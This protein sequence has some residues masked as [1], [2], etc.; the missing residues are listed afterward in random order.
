M[1]YR[2]PRNINYDASAVLESR[3]FAAGIDLPPG[4]QGYVTDS[5]NGRSRSTVKTIT[6]PLWAFN[7]NP[8]DERIHKN[9][10]SYAIYYYAHEAAHA[11]VSHNKV[12]DDS[13]HGRKFYEE[14]KRLCP[15]SLWHYELSYKPRDAKRAGI[16]KSPGINEAMARADGNPKATPVAPVA[17]AAG[18]TNDDDVYEAYVRRT[19]KLQTALKRRNV[20]DHERKSFIRGWA[21]L[22]K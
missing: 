6:V 20:P 12:K 22:D 11:W 8:R 1:A 16:D 5:N 15:P 9:D 18:P 13:P 19:P 14:F 21:K 7:M 2:K 3:A 4:W 10:P 17:L